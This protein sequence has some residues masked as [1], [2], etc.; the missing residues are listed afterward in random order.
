[1]AGRKR[2]VLLLSSWGLL[3]LV[4]GLVLYDPTNYAPA[5]AAGGLR[6]LTVLVAVILGGGLVLSGVRVWQD[7]LD[8]A[9]RMRLPALVLVAI[10]VIFAVGSI[11][12]L[13]PWAYTGLA[14]GI[15]AMGVFAFFV[16][17]GL[18]VAAGLRYYRRETPRI[19]L[20]LL[21]GLTGVGAFYPLDDAGLL[22]GTHPLVYVVLVLLF[23]AGPVIGMFYGW[24]TLLGTEPVTEGEGI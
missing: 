13:R 21:A 4:G 19:P 5:S 9:R 12:V 2:V 8:Y 16:G 23:V 20:I 10:G 15:S 1:M 24:P 11:P 14:G 18:A 17:G 7:G 22:V 3:T 6:W